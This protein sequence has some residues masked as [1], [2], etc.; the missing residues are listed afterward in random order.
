MEKSLNESLQ[1][2]GIQKI[3]R[4]QTCLCVCERDKEAERDRNTDT[5]LHCQAPLMGK[6]QQCGQEALPRGP[7]PVTHP[8]LLLSVMTLSLW[9]WL[10]LWQLV[11]KVLGHQ[12]RDCLER[13]TL[14]TL[15][16]FGLRLSWEATCQEAEMCSRTWD[17][18]QEAGALG[19]NPQGTGQLIR[20]FFSSQVS[21]TAHPQLNHSHLRP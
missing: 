21:N 8:L 10:R 5:G 7:P 19:P 18:L 3:K 2:C 13:L 15:F 16:E 9:T 14:E 6:T 4:S 1:G 17:I 12:F 11:T 20:R